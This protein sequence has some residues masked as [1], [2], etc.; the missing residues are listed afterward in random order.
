MNQFEI[1]ARDSRPFD[2]QKI[3]RKNHLLRRVALIDS[4]PEL[5]AQKWNVNAAKPDWAWL[6]VHRFACKGTHVLWLVSVEKD[7]HVVC[8]SDCLARWLLSLWLRF[9]CNEH[10]TLFQSNTWHGA[11]L[12]G[13]LNGSLVF[14]F[15]ITFPHNSLCAPV[16]VRQLTCVCGCVCTPLGPA[17]AFVGVF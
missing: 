1:A 16:H 15:P 8:C 3:T 17:R 12:K 7:V 6:Q 4:S 10:L 11:A 5:K 9:S 14:N 13:I 2:W